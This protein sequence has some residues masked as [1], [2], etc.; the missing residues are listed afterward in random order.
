MSVT[1]TAEEGHG[2]PPRREG[3][4]LSDQVFVS[5]PSG[6][7]AILDVFPCSMSP[8]ANHTSSPPESVFLFL[9]RALTQILARIAAEHVA[10]ACS[11]RSPRE[12]H[13][14]PNNSLARLPLHLLALVNNSPESKD[15]ANELPAWTSFAEYVRE[16]DLSKLGD[17]PLRGTVAILHRELV[18]AR[19]GVSSVSTV[20]D[21]SP[22]VLHLLLMAKA[23]TAQNCGVRTYPVKTISQT[24][25]V[26][27]LGPEP[28]CEDMN[29]PQRF[30]PTGRNSA[31]LVLDC[32][33]SKI[34]KDIVF[35]KF[36]GRQCNMLPFRLGDVSSLP[37][38]FRAYWELIERCCESQDWD[39]DRGAYGTRGEVA[40]LTV[41]ERE[42]LDVGTS[43]RRGGLHC[44]SVGCYVPGLE[45]S[46]TSARG[47]A[48]RALSQKGVPCLRETLL[49]AEAARGSFVSVRSLFEKVRKRIFGDSEEEAARQAAYAPQAL[50]QAPPLSRVPDVEEGNVSFTSV[51]DDLAHFSGRPA[52]YEIM[53]YYWG[54]GMYRNEER[55]VG[56]IYLASNMDDTCAIFNASVDDPRMIGRLGCCEHLREFCGLP[57]LLKKNQL[58]WITD[59]TP[60]ES[61]PMLKKERRQ[62]FRLVMPEVSLWFKDHSTENSLGVGVDPSKT[63]VVVGNKFKGGLKIV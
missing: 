14:L 13:D 26:D 15:F 2:I 8:D 21:S 44:D 29:D 19:G 61:L 45:Q 11:D 27:P 55:L 18:K 30:A 62:F 16:H 28:G 10:D 60:H 4:Q 7:W 58:A 37:E 59:R 25:L 46:S 40:F 50:Q 9:E 20:G 39:S 34:Q 52:K 47:P 24:E 35:P 32:K 23:V 33:K 49:A 3:E 12:Q 56:G 5:V 6:E 31:L 36:A 57:I 17:S 41:D 22:P 51:F 63:R 42:D 54:L 48:A 38:E 43:H 1:T 53:Y